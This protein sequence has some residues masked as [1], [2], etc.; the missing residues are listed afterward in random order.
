MQKSIQIFLKLVVW[1]ISM[2]LMLIVLIGCNN[3]Q[4]KI[5]RTQN[6]IWKLALEGKL[7]GVEVPIGTTKSETLKILPNP[8]STGRSE[9]GYR[10][11]YEGFSLEFQVY[12]VEAIHSLNELDK[13]A[14]I[15][16]ITAKPTTV[17]WQ[18]TTADVK[19]ALGEP[20]QELD[21]EAYGPAWNQIYKVKDNLYLKFISE[22]KEGPIVK[23]IV[24]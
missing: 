12:G 3:N 1:T 6:E 2:S 24:E 19:K 8:I 4:Q 18:G 5:D 13:N 21:D 23:I 20:D 16:K 11:E 15:Q 14:K 10:L 9:N 17:G 22:T 7:K